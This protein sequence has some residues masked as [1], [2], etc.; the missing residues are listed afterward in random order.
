MHR[1]EVER[2]L[3]PGVVDVMGYACGECPSERTQFA[4]TANPSLWYGRL[5]DTLVVCY[6]EE[7]VCATTRV[8]L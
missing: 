2:L 5:E 6:V 3:G 4:Y 1:H 7:V 8:G